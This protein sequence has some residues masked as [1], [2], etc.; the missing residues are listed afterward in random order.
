MK[1]TMVILFSCLF[2]VKDIH[3]FHLRPQSRC[4]LHPFRSLP[5]AVSCPR[6]NSRLTREKGDQSTFRF[7][8]SRF[9]LPTLQMTDEDATEIPLDEGKVQK[10]EENKENIDVTIE[11]EKDGAIKEEQDGTSEKEQDGKIESKGGEEIVID[12]PKTIQETIVED[13]TKIT[14]KEGPTPM[15]EIMQTENAPLGIGGKGGFTY[16]VNKVKKNLVQESVKQF[17][18]EIL[19]LLEDDSTYISAKSARVTDRTTGKNLRVVRDLQSRD[20]AIEDKIASLVAANPVSTTTDSNLL[21]GSWRFAYSSN[22]A[23]EILLNSR[24]V[25]S[26]SKTVR[27]RKRRERGLEVGDEGSN[28]LNDEEMQDG[29]TQLGA[30]SSKQWNL[31]VG[32]TQNPFQTRDRAIYLENLR[33]EEYPYMLDTTSYW[34]GLWSVQRRYDIIG[35]R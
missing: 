10:E 30:F 34:N 32:K 29:A 9:S 28:D 26:Q 2:L 24:F 27:N 3:A 23:E 7:H 12:K 14:N 4:I 25:L 35:V 33:P 11:E 1:F 17:K 22:N 13:S 16:D 15:S 31:K 6:C 19:S 20:E 21:D 8:P 18:H 5:T